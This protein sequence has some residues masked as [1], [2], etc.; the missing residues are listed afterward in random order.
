MASVTELTRL[1]PKA[2]GDP[3]QTCPSTVPVGWAPLTHSGERRAAGEQGNYQ[4][5]LH[6]LS[7]SPQASPTTHK[8]QASKPQEPPSGSD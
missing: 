5:L 3:S 6:S 7:P 2:P 1:G 4:G 8:G